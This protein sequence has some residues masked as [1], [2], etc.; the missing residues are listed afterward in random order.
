[1]RKLAVLAMVFVFLIGGIS[2]LM[3]CQDND[4][5][6]SDQPAKA[7]GNVSDEALAET[8]V[9]PK[10]SNANTDIVPNLE[11]ENAENKAT[12]PSKEAVKTREEVAG[13]ERKF[14]A[15]EERWIRESID[16]VREYFQGHGYPCKPMSMDM[17]KTMQP[18]GKHSGLYRD[19]VAYL[20][21]ASYQPG[22]L[23]EYAGINPDLVGSVAAHELIHYQTSQA[24]GLAPSFWSE[25][26]TDCMTDEIR[27]EANWASYISG[28]WL[29][30]RF[31]DIIIGYVANFRGKSEAETKRQMIDYFARGDISDFQQFVDGAFGQEVFQKMYGTL[32]ENAEFLKSVAKTKGLD[33]RGLDSLIS[34]AK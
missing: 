19:G 26:M 14:T 29:E 33:V 10:D 12:A 4:S 8:S 21:L 31:R 11:P 23:E 20:A 32:R 2:V 15:R 16:L 3:G 24:T 18:D 1:M 27:K 7:D 25:T 28:Y 5:K 6:G 30:G 22:K 13:A 34:I 17:V 9:I